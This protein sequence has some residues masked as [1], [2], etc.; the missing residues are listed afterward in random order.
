[1]VII[2][3]VN[4]WL[5]IPTAIMSILFYVMRYLYVNTGRSLKRIEALGMLMIYMSN[6]ECR[7]S[8]NILWNF[9]LTK[10][11]ICIK[12]FFLFFFFFFTQVEVQSIRI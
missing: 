7:M 5:L 2:G 10:R 9:I 11:I 12:F 8:T 4:F 6:V 1:M 3:T